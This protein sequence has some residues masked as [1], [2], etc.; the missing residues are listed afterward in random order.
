MNYFELFDI[1][2]GFTID[3]AALKQQYYALSR[4]FHPDFSTQENE[5][6][7]AEMLEKSALLNKAYKMLSDPDATIGYILQEK[8]LLDAEKQQA[9]PPAFLMEMMEVNEA[10]ADAEMD[11]NHAAIDKIAGEIEDIKKELHESAKEDLSCDPTAPASEKALLRIRDYYL[12]KK[13]TQRILERING[14]RNIATRSRE[15]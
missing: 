11:E 4:K 13:Y 1:P 12:K 15:L 8:G 9:L 5:W 6:E 14:I 2:V 3:S 7:Q 10:L